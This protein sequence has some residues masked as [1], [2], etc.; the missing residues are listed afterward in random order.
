MKKKIL[1]MIPL[2]VL[3]SCGT[4]TSSNS[5]PA[6]SSS[7]P[8]TSS[9]EPS[10]SLPA[11]PINVETLKTNINGM[12][13]YQ[14]DVLMTGK[15]SY[16][17]G[18]K[19]SE[20]VETKTKLL[21]DGTA[22]ST[23]ATSKEKITY[24]LTAFAQEVGMSVDTLVAIAK[25]TPGA[26][27]D[28][29]KD[30]YITET[31]DKMNPHLFNYD[32]TAKQYVKYDLFNDKVVNAHY[33]AQVSKSLDDTFKPIMNTAV[34]KGNKDETKGEI[35][36]TF[37]NEFKQS[38]IYQTLLQGGCVA[39]GLTLSVKNNV[40]TKID[41]TIDKAL[42]SQMLGKTVEEMSFV[43]SFSKINDVH[44]SI[45]EGDVK[46]AHH[47][48]EIYSSETEHYYYCPACGILLTDKAAHDFEEDHGI[49]KT[50]G[51]VKG[52]QAHDSEDEHEKTTSDEIAQGLKAFAYY[53]S[54]KG[55]A[56]EVDT[57]VMDGSGYFEI[58]GG[59]G[60]TYCLIEKVVITYS[61]ISTG[62][63]NDT[64]CVN[65]TKNEYKL[66]KNVEIEDDGEG[67]A[68]FDGKTLDEFVASVTPEKTLIGY[69]VNL[70][71]DYEN[72]EEIDIDD[73][74][75]KSVAHCNRCDRD[76]YVDIS[77]QHVPTN[78]KE[79]TYAEFTALFGEKIEYSSLGYHTFEKSYHYYEAEC[80]TCHK[81]IYMVSTYSEGYQ[82]DHAD[83][84]FDYE[85]YEKEGPR[86]AAYRMYLTLG[87][88]DDGTGH[89]LFC[90]EEM[91][92]E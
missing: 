11:N 46:C 78:F 20:D 42:A 22:Y 25:L 5:A 56:F 37:D 41:F 26:S 7:T 50:C 55:E 64:S 74:H 67:H 88:V 33:E 58:V 15:T 27:A 62:F 85:F 23:D 72:S 80:S 39:T 30:T 34:S 91:P 84:E 92:N 89:C 24:S 47:G 40:P 14:A 60:F 12:N 90:H 79:I 51:Y 1:L 43:I 75:Y 28:K 31:E 87:H 69:N 10:S 77:Y 13:A 70:L 61:E 2:F 52:S 63:L 68:T 38:D 16:S 6:S 19:K 81:K 44:L 76:V 21:V 45:P 83:D 73:C 66:Y 82:A 86:T 57:F 48:I 29:A 3:A 35:L 32:A 71:H 53:E 4:S 17:S 49:C 54:E 65:L 9:E 18:S 36:Y 8:T 59:E